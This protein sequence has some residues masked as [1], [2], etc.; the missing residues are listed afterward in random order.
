VARLFK[1]KVGLSHQDVGIM[2]IWLHTF[3]GTG[4]EWSFLHIGE[5]TSHPVWTFPAKSFVPVRNRTV[6][7]PARGRPNAR[8]GDT[9]RSLV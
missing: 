1:R 3:L 2:E 4:C 7:H 9:G 8:C 6:S 5:W